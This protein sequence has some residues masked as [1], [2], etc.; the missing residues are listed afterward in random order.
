MKKVIT[1]DQVE[2]MQLLGAKDKNIKVI[3]NFFDVKIVVRGTKIKLEGGKDELLSIESLFNDMIV[4]INQ[5]GYVTDKDVQVLINLL[6]DSA[7]N[8]TSLIKNGDDSVILHTHKGVIS[9]RTESQKKY[10]RSMIDNDVVFAIGPAGTGKT[11]QAV[12]CAVSSLKSKLVKKIVITRPVVEAGERLG[13]LPGDLK[14]KIDP[15]LTPI[16]DALNEMIPAEKLKKY[17]ST[18]IIE[19][20]PLAYMRGRTLHNSFIILDEAQ[21]ATDAQMKMFLTRL[22]ATSKCIVTGD[23]T[24]VDLPRTQ[25]SGLMNAES[26]LSKVNGIEFIYFD[27]KDVVRHRLVKEIINAYAK[28]KNE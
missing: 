1:I 14:E 5:K 7:D 26:V 27:E 19:I 22:G 11:Y 23:V 6:D 4:T 3:E 18:K 28:E 21:N 10:H 24:Q 16:Y 9:A 8:S 25:V 20:A 2:P 15:Y 13:F 17:M 12:A